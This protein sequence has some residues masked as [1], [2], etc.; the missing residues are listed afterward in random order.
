MTLVITF[1][2]RDRSRTAKKSIKKLMLKFVEYW[3]QY[4]VDHRHPCVIVATFSDIVD[5]TEDLENISN[6]LL[7]LKAIEE[8]GYG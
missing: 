8:P 4:D 2:M 3:L 1:E 6:L 5:T 7:S